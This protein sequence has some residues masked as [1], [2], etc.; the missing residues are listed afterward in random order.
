MRRWHRARRQGCPIYWIR[1]RPESSFLV[2]GHVVAVRDWRGWL[3][4]HPERRGKEMHRRGCP[5]VEVVGGADALVDLRPSAQPRARDNRPSND[6]LA[7]RQVSTRG[8]TRSPKDAGVL[9]A[10]RGVLG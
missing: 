6:A 8:R 2:A 7:S 3:K 9:E 4:I 10:A 1:D 5:G